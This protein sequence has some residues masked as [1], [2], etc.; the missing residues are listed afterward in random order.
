[1]R[2]AK[3]TA[4]LASLLLA[5]AA[6]S[7][8]AKSACAVD[9]AFVTGPT[10]AALSLGGKVVKPAKVR[11]RCLRPHGTCRSH[12]PTG[13]CKRALQQ[14]PSELSLA[15]RV[16]SHSVCASG[17]GPQL[18]RTPVGCSVAPLCSVVVE[19]PRALAGLLDA[20]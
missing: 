11:T 7:A 12:P 15:R 20:G 18:G 5:V 1:M 2:A 17:V 3:A 13:P 10:T 16:A 9:L 8:A 4:L 6:G 14:H 19:P